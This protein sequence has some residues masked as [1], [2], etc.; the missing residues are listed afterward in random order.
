MRMYIAHYWPGMHNTAQM[1]SDAI[2]FARRLNGHLHDTV[3]NLK[4]D[5][6]MRF[7]RSNTQ[8]HFGGLRMQIFENCLKVQ[9]YDS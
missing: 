5:I 3:F 8:L 9:N 1:N 4:Q 6:F 7:G 2:T